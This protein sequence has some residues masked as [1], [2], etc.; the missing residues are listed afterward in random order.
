MSRVRRVFGRVATVNPADG[1][2]VRIELTKKGLRVRVK[3][4][5]KVHQ[6]SLHDVVTLAQGQGVFRL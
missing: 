4:A 1:K 5:R 6:L 3:C 2:T